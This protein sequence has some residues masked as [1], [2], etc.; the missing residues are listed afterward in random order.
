M[1]GKNENKKMRNI[2]CLTFRSKHTIFSW[3]KSEIKFQRNRFK[4]IKFNR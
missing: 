3:L 4:L 1:L 2:K